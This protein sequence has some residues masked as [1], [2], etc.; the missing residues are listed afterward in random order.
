METEERPDNFWREDPEKKV[1]DWLSGIRSSFRRR[2]FPLVLALA[3]ACASPH[4]HLHEGKSERP[5]AAEANRP[6]PLPK[7]RK[8]EINER[9]HSKKRALIAAIKKHF[10]ETEWEIQEMGE[11]DGGFR[12]EYESRELG[13]EPG[14]TIKYLVLGIKRKDEANMRRLVGIDTKTE[15]F[16][17]CTGNKIGRYGVMVYARS[18]ADTAPDKS[19]AFLYS[20]RV[21]LDLGLLSGDAK[22]LLRDSLE[23]EV[24]FLRKQ[25]IGAK[26]GRYASGF[27]PDSVPEELRNIFIVDL[28]REPDESSPY[29][30]IGHIELD[31]ATGEYSLWIGEDTRGEK[32]VGP[33][34]DVQ[35]II[36]YVQANAEN[37]KSQK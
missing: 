16:I 11:A 2:F 21:D 23:S 37:L 14:G 29:R 30:D 35:E 7:E 1:F 5:P 22:V 8:P 3:P 31:E 27:G 28:Y 4:I 15:E 12:E 24:Q 34:Q 33:T 32:V 18:E 19:A 13:E 20:Q 36:R 9:L 10:P 17:I 26:E 6:T 25:G